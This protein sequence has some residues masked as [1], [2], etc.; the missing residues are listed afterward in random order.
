MYRK[1]HHNGR[2]SLVDIPAYLR[3]HDLVYRRPAE[4]PYDGIPLGNG[5]AGGLIRTGPE[6][7]ALTLNHTDC[8]DYREDGLFGAWAWEEEEK[9]TAPVAGAELSVRFS[10]PGLQ[11]LYQD[12]YEQRLNLADGICTLDAE[13][14][15]SRIRGRF[16]WSGDPGV[17]IM[18]FRG[19]F[20]EEVP[21]TLVLEN[22]PSSNFFH[23]YEQIL[24]I[25]DKNLSGTRASL[26]DSH[27]GAVERE[28][29][30]CRSAVAMRIRNL[31]GEPLE[32]EVLRI[33]S[34]RCE[35]RLPGSRLQEFTVLAGLETTL[36]PGISPPGTEP[37]PPLARM[38]EALDR[39]EILLGAEV[40]DDAA[41]NAAPS[42]PA[43]PAAGSAGEAATSP[44]GMASSRTVLGST[45]EVQEPPSGPFPSSELL[46]RHI[47]SWHDFWNR[48]F[49][50]L[51]GEDYL[52]N[53]YYFHLYQ[54]N[55]CSRGTLPVTFA[56]L[57][58]WFRDSRNWGHFYHWNHQQTYWGLEAAGRNE[59][60]ENYYEYRWRM[61]S[62]ALETGR[63]LTGAEGACFYS[64]ITNLNGFNALEPDTLRN[65]TVTAQIALDFHRR[66]RYTGDEDFLVG[67]TAP[68]MKA[69]AELY[70]ALLRRDPDGRWRIRG[71]STPYE[72]YWN[73]RETVTDWS[74][75]QQLFEALLE[76]PDPA[77]PGNELRI[78]LE[79]ILAG[80]P[81]PPVT[82]LE[83]K[84][85]FSAGR[86]GEGAPVEYGQ[87]R[88]PLSPFP[89]ALTAPVYPG[90][91]K[92]L[93]DPE[94]FLSG[95]AR[96]TAR[97]LFDREFYRQDGV[98]DCSGHTPAP[99]TAARLGMGED[100]LK[101]LRHFAR[102][103]QCFPSGFMH[104][105]DLSRDQQWSPVDHPRVLD[106]GISRTLWEELHDRSRGRR[107]SLDSDQFMH[108]YFEPS[109]N[110][111][112]GIQELLLQDHH[113]VIRPFPFPRLLEEAAFTLTAAGGFR[114]S[115]ECR[116]GDPEYL[117]I[118]SLLNPEGKEP[119]SP[120]WGEECR[121]ASPWAPDLT[122]ALS[123][124]NGRP[125]EVLREKGILQFRLSPGGTC[126]ITPAERPLQTAYAGDYE[127]QENREVKYLDPPAPEGERFRAGG[128]R[129]G[130]VQLGLPPLY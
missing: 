7:I 19:E 9:N 127:Y 110:I 104:F 78:C 72:S 114:V 48:S 54:L 96:R 22:W 101:L 8:V 4:R 27:T 35:I 120:L 39:A 52:E 81:D 91:L 64:D 32:A 102:T 73:L 44:Q 62:H 126:L 82:I 23:H 71:G 3:R 40:A 49:L 77:G 68:V 31:K 107:T 108:C 124:E 116:R 16:W 69:A 111:F 123:D 75:V 37:E 99:Q 98:L 28:L 45:G 34:R 103:Y 61:F 29:N 87:G 26:P 129:K 118:E 20:S 57:W 38:L 119:R 95:L 67:R 105:A 109:A 130:T 36:P 70:R 121:L 1:I 24:G 88:Y 125:V 84:E 89:A 15:F 63:Q 59:L 117:F 46:A 58:S 33:H 80:L 100:A 18:E 113:G 86:T 53:L 83:G 13:T 5:R 60:T 79:E 14:P 65:F 76:L 50:H 128:M 6:G 51:G 42:V 21:V 122:L 112:A 66:W 12:N 10:L 11:W 85:I 25:R 17:L 55:S 56:G 92:A 47:R 94:S 90:S 30:R 43:D 74:L 106:P 97:V 2:E 41:S 93:E 115:G